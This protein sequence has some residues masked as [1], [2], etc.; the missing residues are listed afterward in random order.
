MAARRTSEGDAVEQ[1]SGGGDTGELA[2]HDRE[3]DEGR[4]GVRAFGWCGGDDG[5]GVWGVEEAHAQ[6]PEGDFEQEGTSGHRCRVGAHHEESTGHADEA[7]DQVGLGTVAV[8][9]DAK[10]G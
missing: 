2:E 5:G 9:E 3:R 10:E 7:G 4:D 1:G 8:G 6:A